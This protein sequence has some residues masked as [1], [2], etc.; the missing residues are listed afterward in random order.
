[1]AHPNELKV[2]AVLLTA[3]AVLATGLVVIGDRSDLFARK[4]QYLVRF[5][6]VGGLAN[7]A[8]VTLDGVTVGKVDRVVL[9]ESPRQSEIEVWLKVDHRYEKRLRSPAAAQ[10][11]SAPQA[12]KARLKTQG[13]LGDK[14]VDLNSGPVGYPEIPDRG[15]IPA[16]APS[17]IEHLVASGEDVMENVTQL[18]RSLL[19]IVNRL[20]RGEGLLG[21]LTSESA[22]GRR[23]R[24]EALGT[25]EDLRRAAAQL[26]SGQGVLPRLLNDRALAAKLSS[27]LDRLDAA[28]ASFTAGSGPLP[29]L[30]NDP[31]ERARVDDALTQLDGASRDLQQLA[32]RLAAGQGLLPKLVEDKAYGQQVSERLSR[33]VE[34][35]D[36]ISDRLVEGNG[37]AAKLINDPSIYN[38]IN[39]VIVGVDQSWMLRWLIRNRQKAGIKKRYHDATAG[40]G[41]SQPPPAAP[42][43]E[44]PPPPQPPA[45]P[46]PPAPHPC[47]S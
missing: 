41:P 27:T 31:A 6:T 1:M 15:E 39:D 47:T 13:V 5:A 11:A 21:E 42:Q 3:L 20:E 10:A 43:M 7:G 17:N 26:Q 19:D 22:A 30:L 14:Y 45:T 34:R 40:D 16:A 25:M 46:P 35:L 36:T 44:S 24:D 4:N 18:S 29:A 2:G 38:A 12:T 8:A 9:P 37:T 32:G 28:A 23:L 33:V